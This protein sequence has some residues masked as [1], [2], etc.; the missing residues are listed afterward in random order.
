MQAMA[1]HDAVLC[2]DEAVVELLLNRGADVALKTLELGSTALH[3]AA[4]LNIGNSHKRIIRK[5]LESRSD[6]DQRNN[7]GLTSFN[8]IFGSCN[9][10]LVRLCIDRYNADLKKMFCQ[11][12]YNGR[13]AL[14]FAAQNVD[15]GV[16]NLVLESE[17]EIDK[18][19]FQRHTPLHLA[20]QLSIRENVQRLISM[21]AIVNAEDT[22]SYTPLYFSFEPSQFRQGEKAGDQTVACIWK[23]LKSPVLHQSRPPRATFDDPRL[24]DHQ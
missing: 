22:Q 1:L 7:I 17:V 21:G 18:C 6:L 14:S 19:C 12:Y 13:N 16:M 20:S 24:N 2:C 8:Y 15:K 9:V 10:N 11:S 4:M 5:L 3:W 23:Q